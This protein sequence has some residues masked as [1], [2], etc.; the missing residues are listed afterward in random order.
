MVKLEGA[1]TNAA[2]L[3][4]LLEMYQPGADILQADLQV[5]A[6]EELGMAAADATVASNEPDCLVERLRTRL[7]EKLVVQEEEIDFLKLGYLDRTCRT[8]CGR[9]RRVRH[10]SKLLLP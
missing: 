3:R 2:A 5:L 10:A 7:E 4:E 8:C 9:K 6:I 1:K